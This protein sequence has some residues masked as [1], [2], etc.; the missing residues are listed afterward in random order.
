MNKDNFLNLTKNADGQ[1]A[2]WRVLTV[3][4]FIPMFW[5]M[6]DMNQSEWVLQA[7]K[8]NLDLGIYPLIEKFGIKVTALR[9]I[10]SGLFITACSFVIIALLEAKI[11]A[12]LHPSAWW[13]ILAYLLLT[14]REV[15]VVVTCLEYAYTQSLPSMKSTMTA[16]FFFTYPVGTAFTTYVNASIASHGAFRN[17]TGARYFWLFAGIMFGITGLF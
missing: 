4:A 1:K 16:I 13:Q 5:G 8:L 10:G 2:F 9:K 14:A 6:Y 17:F 11:Q 3:F 7:T 15:M 12:G